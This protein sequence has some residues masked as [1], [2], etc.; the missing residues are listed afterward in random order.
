MC[1]GL[2]LCLARTPKSIR[3]SILERVEKL[4]S[5]LK[6][7][8]LLVGGRITLINVVLSNLPIY[9]MSLLRCPRSVAS[10]IER[11][12]RNF[13]WQGGS[14]DKKFHLVDWASVCK[15]KKAGGLGFRP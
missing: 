6:A 2:L 11:L 4:L 13:L 12:E 9:Y 3:N 1:L 10:C 5:S 7:G 14:S 8:Y 15:P